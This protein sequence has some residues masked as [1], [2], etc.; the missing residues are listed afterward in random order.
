MCP[1]TSEV[2]E[3]RLYKSIDFPF[4]WKFYKTIIKNISSVDNII[5]PKNNLWWLL[6]NIDRSNS[7]D[8]TH[9]LSIFYSKDGPLTNKWKYH[10]QNPIKINSLD[11]R[12]AGIIFDKKKI[13]RVSQTQGF[14]NYGEN[15]NFHE[16]KSLSTKNYKEKSFKNKN[17]LRIKKKLNNDDIHHYSNFK[18][19][20][21]V[22]FKLN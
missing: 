1:E 22:D 16:I 2:S 10:P 12:N 7:K 21:V 6:T 8:Y 3:I 18:N 14:D 11:S 20:V 17:F 13:I 4:K 5:F 19:T 9:D 15:L